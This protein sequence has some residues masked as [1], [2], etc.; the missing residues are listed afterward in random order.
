MY[1][2]IFIRILFLTVKARVAVSTRDRSGEVVRAV[3]RLAPNHRQHRLRL[4]LRLLVVVLLLFLLLLLLIIII[5][6]IISIISIILAVGLMVF[7]SF[8]FC[9]FVLPCFFPFYAEEVPFL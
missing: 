3:R 9:F 4:R 2:C 7:V 6:I 5:I 8:S 1:V